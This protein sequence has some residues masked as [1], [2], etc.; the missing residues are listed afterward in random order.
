M[1]KKSKSLVGYS[2]W[3]DWEKRFYGT[4]FDGYYL[5]LISSSKK[6][7]GDS[8]KVRITIEEER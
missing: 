3:K 1:K 5:P 6:V 7:Y 2:A 4:K 8:V